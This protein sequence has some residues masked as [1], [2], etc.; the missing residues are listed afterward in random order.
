MTDIVCASAKLPTFA[1]P[2]AM[3]IKNVF[4]CFDG[5]H[6][7]AHLEQLKREGSTFVLSVSNGTL[8][9]YK[10][11][12]KAL[13]FSTSDY[14]LMLDDDVQIVSP[15]KVL[16]KNGELVVPL[17]SVA[18]QANTLLEFWYKRN[19]FNQ[20]VF[21]EKYRFAPTICWL[22]NAHDKEEII[23]QFNRAPLSGG[24]VKVSGSFKIIID[25]DFHIETNLRTEPAIRRKLKRQAFGHALLQMEKNPSTWRMYFFLKIAKNLLLGN[26][27]IILD[28]SWVQNLKA[29][30]VA[31][32]WKAVYASFVIFSSQRQIVDRLIDANEREI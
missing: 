12:A 27:E 16:P 11:R 31:G 8:G 7:V 2:T 15:P 18:G 24:D 5:P 6:Q 26:G 3:S 1:L 9:S 21:V 4:V 28:R 25:Q 19:A 13:S 30:H 10:T 22:V 29:R 32:F 14:I 20:R 23:H 17:I